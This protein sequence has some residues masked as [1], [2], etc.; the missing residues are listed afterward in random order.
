MLQNRGCFCEAQGLH[1]VGEIRVPPGYLDD[2]M[3]LAGR[4][5]L[6]LPVLGT[7]DELAHHDHEAVIVAIGHNQVRQRIFAALSASDERFA[8][9]RHPQAIVAPDVIIHPGTMICAGAVV[10]SGS[11]IGANVILNTGCTVDHH[12]VIG[13]HVHIAPG[14]HIGGAVHV[15]EGALV[16]IGATLLP[17]I[18]VGAWAIVGAGACVTRQVDAGQT[19]VGVPARP[20]ARR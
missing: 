7:L 12:C 10:N 9:A 3:Q 11:V 16:G 6:G 2:N 1:R 4:H 13:D 15:D 17:Q 18:T 20:L 14:V 19:V 8:I 5:L